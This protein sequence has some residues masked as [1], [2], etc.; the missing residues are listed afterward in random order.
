MP[1]QAVLPIYMSLGLDGLVNVMMGCFE[2]IVSQ[3]Y[4]DQIS[5]QVC[6]PGAQCEKYIAVHLWQKYGVNIR[7]Y[8]QKYC[9][10]GVRVDL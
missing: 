2:I 8:A 1:A 3:N 9:G 6:L 10:K 4:F 7:K 5:A